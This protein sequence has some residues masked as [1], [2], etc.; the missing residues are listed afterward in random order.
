MIGCLIGII[1]AYN[2]ADHESTG[3]AP[4]LR[5]FWHGPHLAIGAFLRI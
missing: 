4:F 2:A 5:M 3:F 1:N